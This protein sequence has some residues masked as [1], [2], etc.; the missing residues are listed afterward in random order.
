MNWK[1]HTPA[2]QPWWHEANQLG[3]R[4]SKIS[5]ARL[6]WDGWNGPLI[7]SWIRVGLSRASL[8]EQILTIAGIAIAHALRTGSPADSID[9]NR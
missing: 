8:S 6:S 2:V 5:L 3:L 4:N 9:M 7:G 1:P